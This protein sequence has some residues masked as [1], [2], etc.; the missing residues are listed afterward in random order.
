LGSEVHHICE[1]SGTGAEIEL[2]RIPLHPDVKTAAEQLRAD[3]YQWALSGGEDFELLF[4][5]APGKLALLEQT[6]V[7][8]HMVGKV[9]DA[10]A[11]IVLIHPNGRRTMLPRGYDHFK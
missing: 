1:Q 5:I 8:F 3:P 11:G 6:G 2:K 10:S 4:S 9:T 7:Q